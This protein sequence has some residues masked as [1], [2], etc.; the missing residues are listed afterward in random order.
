MLCPF[1]YFYRRQRIIRPSGRII[2]LKTN[3]FSN[4]LLVQCIAYFK[5]FVFLLF[6]DDPSFTEIVAQVEFAIEHGVMPERIY[7]GSSGS[8]FVKNSSGV[9]ICLFFL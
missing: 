4:F 3:F 1:Q 5:N 2:I 6:T 8:Y 9:I 7:Q